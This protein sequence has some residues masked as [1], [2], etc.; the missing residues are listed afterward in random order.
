MQCPCTVYLGGGLVQD[1]VSKIV[2]MPFLKSRHFSA[3][4]QQLQPV[5][6][7]GLEHRKAGL[8]IFPIFVAHEAVVDQGRQ[9]VQEVETSFQVAHRLRR[10]HRKASRKDGETGVERPYVRFQEAVTPLERVAKGLVSDRQ[11]AAPPLSSFILSS[12]RARIA[13]GGRS[14]TRAAASSSASGS[15]STRRQISAT[16]EALSSVSEKLGCVDRARSTNRC[17]NS[18]AARSSAGAPLRGRSNGGTGYSC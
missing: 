5:C 3:R 18:L 7:N 13:C 15:P 8:P 4:T 2:R 11:V 14:L 12:R 1:H 16:S 9:A 6:S 10:F 17:T